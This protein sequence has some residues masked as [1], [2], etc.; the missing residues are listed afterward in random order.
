MGKDVIIISALSQA[1]IPPPRETAL[2]EYSPQFKVTSNGC[3]SRIVSLHTGIQSNV[4]WRNWGNQRPRN[5]SKWSIKAKYCV[6]L[7]SWDQVV[8]EPP[9]KVTLDEGVQG[10]HVDSGA[11]KLNRVFFRIFNEIFQKRTMN[12]QEIHYMLL[13]TTRLT[14]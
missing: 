8:W 13:V 2:P 5:W 10:N 9:S 6:G 1:V 3:T 4:G 11:Q 7:I 14:A 12:L